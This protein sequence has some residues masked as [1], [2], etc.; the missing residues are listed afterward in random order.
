[1]PQTT[2]LQDVDRNARPDSGVTIPPDATSRAPVP[3]IGPA[4]H[5]PGV[6]PSREMV[7][8][9]PRLF[10]SQYVKSLPNYIDDVTRDFGS[11]L[12]E[13]MLNDSQVFSV[14]N[15]LKI[16]IM[17]DG[18]HVVPSVE[19]K[20]DPE[21]ETAKFWADFCEY[22]ITHLERPFESF[23]YEMLDHLALGYKVAEQTWEKTGYKEHDEYWTLKTLKVK[24]RGTT[25][26]VV[27]AWYNMIGVLGLLPGMGA[28]VLVGHIVA[29]PSRLPNILPVQKFVIFTHSPRDNDP[30]GRAL[31]PST[32]IPTP[33]GWKKLDEIG[34]GD[35]VF[36]EQGKI[37]YV[38]AR[39][40]WND[41]PCYRVCFKDGTSIIADENHQWVT[42]NYCERM[43]RYQ[44]KIRSTSDIKKSLCR[45]TVKR[46]KKI[47]LANHSVS[48]AGALD[49]PEQVLPVHPYYLGLWLGDGISRTAAVSCNAWDAEEEAM[50]IRSCGYSTKIIHN[51]SKD[52]NGR[53]IVVKGDKN[54]DSRGPS[55]ALRMLGL[56][57]NK[58]I[59]KA[60][61]QS[62][63]QQRL[64]LLSGLM[65]SDGSV[66]KDGGCEFSNTNMNLIRGVAELVRSLGVGASI[67]KRKNQ[68]EKWS[69][70]WAV[71]FTPPFSPFRLSRKTK[72]TV[73]RRAYRNHYI[74][75]VDRVS[76]RRT[77]CIEVDSPSHLYLAGE[78]MVPTH[79]SI[80]RPVYDP[81]WIK[82]QV[83]GEYLKF[84]AQFATGSLWGTTPENAQV[85]VEVDAH[86]NPTGV[87]SSTPEEVLVSKLQALENGSVAAFPFGTQ[88]NAIQ[89]P[90]EG[91][92]HLAAIDWCDKQIAKAVLNQTLA[93]EEA[94]HMAR[95][96]ADRH[97]D[98]FEIGVRHE[99]KQ[100]GGFIRTQIFYNLIRWN[101]GE[102]IAK[103]FTP[104]YV[105][106]TLG[107][108]GEWNSEAATVNSL[109]QN[110]MLDDKQRNILLDRIGL[111]ARKTVIMPNMPDEQAQAHAQQMISELETQVPQPKQ[112]VGEG[113]PEEAQKQLRIAAFANESKL[114]SVT[115]EDMDDAAA[116]VA[117]F[118]KSRRR[119]RRRE[120][121][122]F[123]SSPQASLTRLDFPAM[124]M[125]KQIGDRIQ[126]NVAAPT[127]NVPETVVNF[128]PTI[129][130]PDITIMSPVNNIPPMPAPVVNVAAPVVY[131]KIEPP[132]Q[133]KKKKIV[134]KRDDGG[135]IT[136]AKV[137]E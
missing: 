8:A 24:P 11:D 83:K 125:A 30:R 43:H 115:E 75:S 40:D 101:A 2:I 117:K 78:S 15:L 128:N 114:W 65:D 9:E 57:K 21:Y 94:E 37:R 95:A 72:K 127:V 36:D 81:W 99:R 13:R 26:F 87:I 20:E 1:M 96:A 132:P 61:M 102:A 73:C 6:D 17:A 86:G 34:V 121:A 14:V 4:A 131:N 97:Q 47:K 44:G 16:A 22:N 105:L 104:N 110:P 80:L 85:R 32:P 59:P 126:V 62:S 25:A 46:G 124:E 119:R 136:E 77:V 123:S 71:K 118:S 111:P 68:C 74:V 134:F 133:P 12:Y 122:E 27:D 18:G 23:L 41:R 113:N 33:D 42:Q 98:I 66:N 52:G 38:T 31:D 135:K 116:F 63:R 55:V 60:Y 76:P 79:N 49:Y 69:D 5:R 53:L 51:G 92:P 90:G 64:D 106:G 109:L 112:Q 48:W 108:H 93:T 54:W 84:L 19:D 50:S 82:G 89:V 100:C 91:Q 3:P 70:S 129:K 35:K 39:A 67:R 45:N 7:S 107:M 10:V 58:H 88:I 137:E 29:D 28:P 56:I 103:R 130:V 120:R